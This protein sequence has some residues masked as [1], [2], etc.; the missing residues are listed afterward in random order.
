MRECVQYLC[1][2]CAC[3]FVSVCMSVCMY[4][5]GHVLMC[6]CV[7]VCAYMHLCRIHTCKYGCVLDAHYTC[8]TVNICMAYDSY[9]LAQR[10]VERAGSRVP[11]GSSSAAASWKN[12]TLNPTKLSASCYG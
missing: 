10:R 6:V 12:S 7:C 3:V 9:V 8:K 5:Y 2:V 4:V 11:Q 1:H